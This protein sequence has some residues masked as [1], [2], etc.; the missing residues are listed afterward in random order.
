MIS[1]TVQRGV[2]MNEK[3]LFWLVKIVIV[4]MV[5]C[6]IAFNLFLAPLTSSDVGSKGFAIAI[7][8]IFQSLIS[9]PCFFVLIIAW[10]IS[11]DMQKGRLFTFENANRV[12]QASTALFVSILGFLFGKV[13]FYILGWNKELIVHLI[14]LIVGLSILVLM[15]VLSHYIYCAA[16]L[17]EESDFT[18]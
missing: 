17:Q 9:I 6:G 14:I 15:L 13:L 3:T 12:R 5:I 16:K 11:L 7:Q 4:I 2:N 10:K 1:H 8:C 18:V